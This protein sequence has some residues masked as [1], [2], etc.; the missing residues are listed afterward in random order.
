MCAQRRGRGDSGCGVIS[1]P[2]T[3]QDYNVRLQ[4]HEGSGA[5]L[6]K[7]HFV[8]AAPSATVCIMELWADLQLHH[9]HICD[10]I[11]HNKLPGTRWEKSTTFSIYKSKQRRSHVRGN[12]S[13]SSP[14][15]IVFLAFLQKGRAVKGH[16]TR[17]TRNKYLGGLVSSNKLQHKWTC[18]YRSKRVL[19]RGKQINNSWQVQQ[20]NGPEHLLQDDQPKGHR[21]TCNRN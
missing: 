13:I 21:S 20:Y 18:N 8:A 14:P 4:K 17:Y 7:R 11:I 19:L 12:R 3:L 5:R 15:A 10:S 2:I 1:N 16:F 9:K 6:H